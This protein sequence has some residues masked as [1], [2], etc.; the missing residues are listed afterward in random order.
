[1]GLDG[2][3]IYTDSPYDRSH[4]PAVAGSAASPTGGSTDG[5]ALRGSCPAEASEL[6]LRRLR[7]ERRR[8]HPLPEASGNQ[9]LCGARRPVLAGGR[10]NTRA[11]TA[12]RRGLLPATARV[13]VPAR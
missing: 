11:S 3:T 4:R 9:V 8:G 5:S 10:R 7:G 1:M 12:Q 2:R 13:A 6:L